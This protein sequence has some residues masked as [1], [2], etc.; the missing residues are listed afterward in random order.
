MKP[1]STRQHLSIQAIATLIQNDATVQIANAGIEKY[2]K[3]FRFV[4]NASIAGAK[5]SG[6]SFSN[7]FQVDKYYG[8]YSS[9]IGGDVSLGNEIQTIFTA[10]SVLKSNVQSV[11]FG[12]K[13]WVN[14]RFG[15][16][17]KAS[18]NRQGEFYSR[19]GTSFGVIF[20]F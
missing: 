10:S 18:F 4:Y 3:S 16:N 12:G 11:G 14:S 13:H 7:R 17:W 2:W 5:G 9:F 20:R 15:I 1:R 8:K 6:A 19:G